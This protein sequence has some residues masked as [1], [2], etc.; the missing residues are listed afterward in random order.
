MWVLS[1]P[2]YKSYWFADEFLIK[3]GNW[4]VTRDLWTTFQKNL[5]RNQLDLGER[6][7]KG[8][9]SSSQIKIVGMSG[10]IPKCV[11]S[12]FFGSLNGKCGGMVWSH[13]V[14]NV[15]AQFGTIL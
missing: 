15:H 8:S 1:P 5:T 14:D 13:M 6:R 4:I 2:I 7:R 10:S 12:I 3:H 9:T 11:V